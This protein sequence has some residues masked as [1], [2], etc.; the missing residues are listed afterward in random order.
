MFEGNIRCYEEI[1]KAGKKR[2][3][4]KGRNWLWLRRPTSNY[5]RST[6]TQPSLVHCFKLLGAYSKAKTKRSWLEVGWFHRELEMWN[7]P[8]N[9]ILERV[10]SDSLFRL[11]AKPDNYTTI[12]ILFIPVI[13]VLLYVSIIIELMMHL[14]ETSIYIQND[15]YFI[16]S[17]Y[18]QMFI[19]RMSSR[20]S[21]NL[22]INVKID[23]SFQLNIYGN[24]LE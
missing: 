12:D 3:H 23:G 13:S 19:F 5:A 16:K 14:D 24:C 10:W 22:P 18:T 7:Q 17:Q 1:W 4:G 9:G 2:T 15:R 20:I 6:K 11:L 8:D 21:M